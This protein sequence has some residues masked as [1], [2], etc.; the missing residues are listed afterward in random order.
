MAADTGPHRLHR[1]TDSVRFRVTALATLAVIAVLAVGSLALVAGQRRLLRD[2][3]EDRL[4]QVTADLVAGGEGRT[5][6]DDGAYQVIGPDGAVEAASD[7]VTGAAPIADPPQP[8]RDVAVRTGAVSVDDGEF[9]I[10]TRRAPDGTVAHAAAPLDDV[11]EAVATLATV[12]ALVVPAVVA[13][14][15]AIVWWLVGRTLRP[16]ASIREEVD[17]VQV[18]DLDRR[19]PVPA[20]HDE[21]AELARTM[22]AMLDRV[23]SATRR[24]QQFVADASH[25]LRSPLTRIRAELEVDLA[26]PARA[27][28]LATHRSVLAETEGLQRL[29]DDLL[30]LAR[31]DAGVSPQRA[32][33]VDLDDLV[34]REAEWLRATGSIDVDLRAVSAAQVVGDRD[35]LTRAIH[36]LAGNA[37]RHAERVVTF[38]LAEL[39]GMAVLTVGDDGA[40]IPVEERERVFERFTRLDG[41]RNP[42]SGGSGLG[43]AITREIVEGHG[44]RISVDDTGTVGA[45]F[46]VVLPAAGASSPGVTTGPATSS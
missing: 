26:H 14:L 7:N 11:E 33:P 5:V 22:N 30:Q 40:G 37:E 12:L 2:D 8:G 10:V 38:T 19:V 35:Q 29:V 36:N 13:L 6:D 9:L 16:V 43:L 3:L 23:A 18:D 25:E 27:D 41:A 46:L 17:R 1:V 4:R 32:Q 44:G 15:A 34:L 24:Q 28:P 31:R 21:I 20:S 45:R 39:D 42:A